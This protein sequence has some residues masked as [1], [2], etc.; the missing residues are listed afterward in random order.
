M[1]TLKN[2]YLR[3]TV[4]QRAEHA[5]MLTSF[6]VLALTGLPQKYAGNPTADAMIQLFGGIETTR[7]IH[8]M[9]AIVLM[10]EAVFHV[11]ALSYRL[12]VKRAHPSMLPGIRDATDGWQALLY[13]LGIFK[14]APQMGRYTFTEKIEYWSLVWGTV[15]MIITGFMIWNPIATARFLPGQFIP[16]AKA[17]HGGEALLAVLAVVVWHIYHVHVRTFNR[18]MFTGVLTEEQMAHEHPLELAAIKAGA[19]RQPP[20]ATTL[21]RR[22]LVFLPVALLLSGA[23]LLGVYAFTTFE[24]TAIT[25]LPPAATVEVFV[26]LTPTPIPATPTPVPV[27]ASALTWD[28]YVGPL[29]ASK[30]VACHGV[31]GGLSLA[32][33]ADMQK[34]SQSGPVVDSGNAA[35]SL[36]VTK[37]AGGTHPGQLSDDE[38]GKLKDWIDAGAPES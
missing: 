7:V 12:Y 24:Q 17:A 19:V 30:C 1:T 3:F 4:T 27:V 14:T 9:A 36:L 20:D 18:S 13:N 2:A 25:T 16:A 5:I 31:L 28:G 23:L 29:L 33:Y 15:I 34:G 6:V 26:P 21:R 10:L 35:N 38:L 32:S 8:R 22:R 37:I 11:V